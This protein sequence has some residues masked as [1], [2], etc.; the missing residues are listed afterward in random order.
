MHISILMKSLLPL[1]TCLTDEMVEYVLEN[2][3]TIVKEY[4]K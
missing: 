1:H 3:T 2:Y 4:L